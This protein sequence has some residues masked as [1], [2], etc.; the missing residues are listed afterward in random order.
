MTH[1]SAHA[2]RLL[3]ALTFVNLLNFIDRQ[4]F[5]AV[6]P[7]IKDD[8]G[9]RDSQL[10]LAGSAFIIVYMLVTPLAG[11]LG[12]RVSR[13]QVV[14]V[15]L[16]LWSS[17]TVLSGAAWS[18]LSLLCFR[19]LV[20]I[21][22]AC[23]A[24]LSTAMIADGFAPHRRGTSLAVFNLAVP[25]GSAFGYFLGGVLGSRFGWRAAFYGVGVPGLVLAGLL[26]LL[27]EPRRGAMDDNRRG[28]SRQTLSTLLRDPV[29]VTT[30]ASMAALTFVL[31]ALAAWMPT[32]LVRLHGFSLADAGTTFGIVTA[33]A[34]LIGTALGGWLGD[35]ALR[36]DPRG[37]LR[38]SGFGLVL[39]V[40]VTGL[41]IVAR[42]PLV[43]WTATTL[44][45]IL[46]F[47]NVGPLNAVIVGAAAP[48]IRATAVAV[49]ILAIH[50][51]G[52]ALSP[53]L[54]GAL[55]DRFGLR[56]ALAIM[57]PMLLVSA[58]L[59]LLAARFVPASR[60]P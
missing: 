22:E 60:R 27:E 29:Y 25:L 53:W 51:L 34:G 13:L 49:N 48:P 18:F 23:Y 38:V 8:L 16:V 15:G 24:P 44:A 21:G 41:A 37:H 57:P 46:V 7:A 14:S 52:D 43:F 28:V 54:V 10:G 40:P 3:G 20:G 42:D 45:E 1:S 6:F 39:A 58:G 56:L 26:W 30:T 12:D 2:A 35:R 31:G 47:L 4:V 11:R 59:C 55:S 33:G 36:R 50:L 19:A 32:F 17:A 9:L 5:Y